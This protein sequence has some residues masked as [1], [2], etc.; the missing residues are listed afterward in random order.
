MPETL[1]PIVFTASSSSFWRRPVM[2]IYAPSLTKRRAVANPIPSVPPVM[3]ATFPSNLP[4][5]ISP[6]KRAQSYLSYRAFVLPGVRQ[7]AKTSLLLNLM[8]H[9]RE[10]FEQEWLLCLGCAHCLKVEM[11]P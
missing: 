6:L 9:N 5:A 11:T 4:I 10:G 1:L 8:V 2:K 3:T 7:Q